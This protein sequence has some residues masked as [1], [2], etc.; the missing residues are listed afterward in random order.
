MKICQLCS[1]DFT[2]YHFLLPLMRAMREAG[3]EV[4]GVCGEGPFAERVRAAGFRVEAV[5]FR[6]NYDVLHHVRVY[7]EL[8]RLFQRERF[9]MVHVHSPIAA[10]IG[11]LA[12]ARAGVPKKVYT[13][14]GFYFHEH[15]PWGLRHAFIGL[16]WIGGRFTDVLFTQSTEDAETARDLRLCRGPVIEAIG[17]G[18]DPVRFWP[19][20]AADAARHRLR[21]ELG[22]GSDDVVILMIGRLVAEKGYPELFAAMKGVNAR[23]W[24]VGNRLKSDHAASVDDAIAGIEADPDLSRRISFLGYRSDVDALLRAADIFTLP[25]HREGMPRSI[26]EAMMSGL[27]VVATDIRGSREEVVDG[28][29]GFLVPVRDAGRLTVALQRLVTDGRL[30]SRLGAAGRQR[31][32]AQFDEEKVVARQIVH[33]G[34]ES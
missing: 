14:H 20:D 11:R 7:G 27:P 28:E 4:V 34:L 13:A 18:V 10:L 22:A 26:I 15:Q 5:G 24:V 23:L 8:V 21:A 30:R 29:T 3:H 25:S 12:A 2:L 17:N 33:L 6:R 19:A 1:V 31:A 9:D 16:E 32:L